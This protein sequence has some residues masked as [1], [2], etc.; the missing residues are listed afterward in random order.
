MLKV[1]LGNTGLQVSVLALGTGTNGWNHRSDQTRRGTDWLVRHLRDG[2]DMGVTFWDVADQYGSHR[3]AMQA[4]KHIERENLVINTKTTARDYQ[5]CS[6]D[7]ERFLK[8]LDTDYLDMVLLHGKDS[9]DWNRECRGAMDAL[10]DAKKRGRVRAV[11]I[12]SHRLDGIKTAAAE[13]WLDVMLVT[14]NYASVR[15]STAQEEVVPVLRQAR[16]RG[17]GIYAMKVLGCGRLAS[18]PEKAIQYILDL[19]CVHAMTIGHTASTQLERNV[20]IIERLTGGMR[21]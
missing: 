8:E 4:L 11:G 2:Y 12:S 9:S 15:M 16:A 21:G 13:S 6:Q 5:A 19:G 14:L 17:K 20:E 10:D 1:D 3:C 7:V 18:D